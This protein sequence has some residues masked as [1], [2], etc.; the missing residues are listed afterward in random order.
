VAKFYVVF[1]GHQRGVFENWSECQK[2]TVG[3]SRAAHLKFASKEAAETAF[4]AYTPP[5]VD[6]VLEVADSCAKFTVIQ[7]AYVPVRIY[8]DGACPNNPDACGSTVVIA[9]NQKVKD[10]WFGDYR[11]KG[12]HNEAELRALLKALQFAAKYTEQNT[13]VEII[14]TSEYSLKAVFE[15]A[16][17]WAANNWKK[18][19]GPI[20]NLKLVKDCYTKAQ[21]LG[22]YLQVTLAD[23]RKSNR[24][25]KLADHFANQA[26]SLAQVA[27]RRVTAEEYRLAQETIQ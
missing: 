23:G 11:N 3:Y 26:V 13:T 6:E 2:A 14:S 5:K 9:S 20:A 18:Q 15:W 4:A 1:E 27:W 7:R 22:R 19:N 12:T 10:A 21:Q 8:C 24:G 16:P 17:E 25:T